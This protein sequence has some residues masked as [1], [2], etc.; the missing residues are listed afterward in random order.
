MILID[1][2]CGG[3]NYI[4][5][6]TKHVNTKKLPYLVVCTHVHF[7]HIGANYQFEKEIEPSKRF[8][9]LI[10]IE[11]LGICM[12]SNNKK[13]TENYEINSLSLAHSTTVKNF[14]ITR[15]L[16]EGDRIYLDDKNAREEEALEVLFTPGHT[17]D[18]ISLVAPFDKRI[19]IGDI[20]CTFYAN[21]YSYTR[22]FYCNS[23]RFHRKLI[24]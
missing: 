12:G 20:L 19:F 1:T 24:E 2:G 7:D 8:S 14:T 18:S 6:V 23:F 5:Y 13:F 3:N 4:E 22:S 15:W 21:F 17:P 9:W 10:S 11:C 16:S